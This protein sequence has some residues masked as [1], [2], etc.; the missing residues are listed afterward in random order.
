MPNRLL[1]LLLLTIP[2]LAHAGLD[3]VG[4][5]SSLDST[6]GDAISVGSMVIS[7]VAVLVSVSIILKI[8]VRGGVVTGKRNTAF[9]EHK[10]FTSNPGTRY[11]SSYNRQKYNNTVY[12]EVYTHAEFVAF[13]ARLHEREVEFL[14][15]Q[16]AETGLTEQQQTD[17][18]AQ[19]EEAN[20]KIADCE[21]EQEH[22]QEQMDYLQYSL[23][24]VPVYGDE[25]DECEIV[26]Y[27]EEYA[28]EERDRSRDDFWSNEEM[29]EQDAR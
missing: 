5:G 6:K 3:V 16:K 18:D 17:I 21:A 27:Q 23:D 12:D 19:I 9:T 15:Q 10:Q 7:L 4:V 13:T 1:A 14:K 8:I 25:E 11:G 22:L 26:D 24:A 29:S 20:S 2:A 28:R